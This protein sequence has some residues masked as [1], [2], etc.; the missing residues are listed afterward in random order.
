MILSSSYYH[1]CA[2]PSLYRTTHLKS[3]KRFVD[4]ITR[5]DLY[6]FRGEFRHARTGLY[7]RVPFDL[8]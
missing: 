4:R 2:V 8:I 3:L 1:C 7:A 5:D 6:L